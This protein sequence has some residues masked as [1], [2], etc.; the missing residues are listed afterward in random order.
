MPRI[1]T[2]QSQVGIPTPSGINSQA[3]ANA[4]AARGDATSSFANDVG[5]GISFLGQRLEQQEIADDQTKTA[6]NLAEYQA[7]KTIE[8]KDALAQ[9]D[10]N[11][12]EFSQ[13]WMNEVFNPGLEAFAEKL[14][15]AQGRQQ[16]ARAAAEMRANFSI[17]TALGMSE[18]QG[19]NAYNMAVSMGNNLS[20]SIRADPNN[21]S[22]SLSLAEF[23]LEGSG[24]DAD[25]KL[26]MK[27]KWG[28]EFSLARL[29][30]VAQTNPEAAQAELDGGRLDRYLD[31]TD[32][33][34]AAAHI[35]TMENV[36]KA[37]QRE[38][39]LAERQRQEA[40][41]SKITDEI[42]RKQPILPDGT[43]GSYPGMMRDIQ[44]MPATTPEQVA[45]KRALA[46]DL[47]STIAAQ[48]TGVGESEDASTVR[49]F[50]QRAYLPP[51]DPNRL[52]P[53]EVLQARA[54][55]RIKGAT[56]DDLL[57]AVTGQHDPARKDASSDFEKWL[58]DYK[59]MITRSSG[60]N[61]LPDPTGDQRWGEFEAQARTIMRDGLAAGMS[62]DAIKERVLRE[63]PR[64]QRSTDQITRSLEAWSSNT[65]ITPLPR[66]P[67]NRW[68]PGSPAGGQTSFPGNVSVRGQQDNTGLP[69]GVVEHGTVTPWDAERFPPV[70]NKDGS[71]SNVIT[72]SFNID[73]VE[74]LIPTMAGGVKMTDEQ[75]I[76]RYSET[77]EHFGKFGTPAEAQRAANFLES[78][79]Q[80]DIQTNV[81]KRKPGET[82]QQWRARTRGAGPVPLQKNTDGSFSGRL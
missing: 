51:S 3:A 56:R 37:E 11:D 12:T 20:S 22:S 30:G 6:T 15:T 67:V 38:V 43:R 53:A 35:R 47:E 54:D 64:F 45:L 9:A 40:E 79:L 61:G 52:T 57:Q 8:W 1:R 62:L 58:P 4:G 10:P 59:S 41:F 18:L 16:Y 27:A 82:V 21:F 32:K 63:M 77:G 29:Y 7:Q 70:Q 65:P 28:K 48:K 66:Q 81:Q 19:I 55:Q 50:W 68:F 31:A 26:E 23:Y 44:N 36:Q 75:S 17:K 24:L 74:V 49:N 5:A 39:A 2:Y 14:Q 76:A 33:E 80:K 73:G 69:E 13:K 78:Q 71:W 25:K 60:I 42:F 34:T 46:N 72:K